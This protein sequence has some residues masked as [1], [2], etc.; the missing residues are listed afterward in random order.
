M[1]PVC[2]V[3]Q[4]CI[5]PKQPYMP[6]GILEDPLRHELPLELIKR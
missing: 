6:C 4:S 2:T 3:I 5:E 1:T